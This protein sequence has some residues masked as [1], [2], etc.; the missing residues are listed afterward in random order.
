[1]KVSIKQTNRIK[2]KVVE[3]PTTLLVVAIAWKIENGEVVYSEPKIVKIIPKKTATISGKV[4]NETNPAIAGIVSKQEY[5][6]F[7]EAKILSPYF[8]N[9]I[10]QT[11][12]IIT[13]GARP[14]CFV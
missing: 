8:S 6:V 1:M 3:T 12:F 7:Q 13:I 4:S 2:F 10:F 14:P 9:S 5:E 11:G